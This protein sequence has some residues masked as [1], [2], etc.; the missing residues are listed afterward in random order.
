MTVMMSV[1]VVVIMRM[2]IVAGCSFRRG[3]KIGLLVMVR[4][5]GESK[6]CLRNDFGQ[7]PFQH[8][9]PRGRGVQFGLGASLHHSITPSLRAPG[10]EDEDDDED[11]NEAPCERAPSRNGKPRVETLGF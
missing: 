4:F 7:S 9:Q 8:P 1:V 10:F 11:E 5:Q 6:L 3:M 2:L